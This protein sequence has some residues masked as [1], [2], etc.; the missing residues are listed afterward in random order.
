MITLNITA[1]GETIEVH[2]RITRYTNGR[3]C[4]ELWSEV[5][6][7][8]FSYMEPYGKLTVNMPEDH[9]NEGE[10]F[11]KD[12][13][14]NEPMVEALKKAGWIEST[15]RE[16]LSGYVVPGVYRATGPLLQEIEEAG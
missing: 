8:G 7:D 16:V 10:F 15:G 2:P 11:V 4:I 14:E 1:W 13:S 9:L 3:L 12:W 6:E 5:H